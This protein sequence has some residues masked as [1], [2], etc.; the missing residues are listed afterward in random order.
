M[1]P[2]YRLLLGHAGGAPLDEAGGPP[3]STRRGLMSQ[4]APSGGRGEP[5]AAPNRLAVAAAADAACGPVAEPPAFIP[6]GAS[7]LGLLGGA[8]GRGPGEAEWARAGWVYRAHLRLVLRSGSSLGDRA[9]FVY[10]R[11]LSSWSAL[12]TRHEGGCAWR[13]KSCKREGGG[14]GRAGP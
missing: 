1:P 2:P 11:P 13:R 4:P 14:A 3:V 12:F 7:L 10:D 5:S 6:P 9:E 8:G